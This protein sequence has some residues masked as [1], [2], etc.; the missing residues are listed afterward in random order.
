MIYFDE[1]ALVGDA[2]GLPP[3]WTDKGRGASER[4]DEPL[5]TAPQPEKGEEQR[6]N[7][8]GH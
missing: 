2:V 3:N 4:G 5:A 6:D 8:V 7:E 1:D